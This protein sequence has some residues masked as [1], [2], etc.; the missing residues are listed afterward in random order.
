M[1]IRTNY[2]PEITIEKR[3]GIVSATQYLNQV[4][5]YGL[6]GLN[7]KKAIN[8]AIK[9]ITEEADGLGANAII[10]VNFQPISAG[11]N[12]DHPMILVV[13]EAVVLKD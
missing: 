7:S 10:G 1:E 4:G 2:P 13:G 6:S 12:G 9:L 11:Q 8:R 5:Q 3:L